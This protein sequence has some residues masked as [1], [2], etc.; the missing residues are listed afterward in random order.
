V[1]KHAG[2]ELVLVETAGIGQEDLPFGR[3]M[4][5]QQVFVMS[6]DYGST[7]QLHKI[8]MLR[9]ADVVVVNKFDRPAARTALAEVQGHLA[10]NGHSAKVIAT[11]AKSHRD[12]GVDNLFRELFS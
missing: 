12:A 7:L 9:A 8:L 10:R 1:L 5:D 4:V 11:V 2:F 6:P 3:G